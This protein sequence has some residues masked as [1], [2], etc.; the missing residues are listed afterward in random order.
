MSGRVGAYY[1][2]YKYK[3]RQQLD[4]EIVEYK[5]RKNIDVRFA[6]DGAV[7]NTTGTYIKKGLPMHPSYGKPFK[8][9]QFPCYDGD[10]V[11]IVE[12]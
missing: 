3:N 10:I 8:G 11:E 12:G 9:Q 6:I 5:G 1:V 4:V 7:V 2:G